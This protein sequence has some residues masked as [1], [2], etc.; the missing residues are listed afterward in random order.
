MGDLNNTTA[1]RPI[2][3]IRAGPAYHRRSVAIAESDD[4]PEIRTKYRPFL[5]DSKTVNEDWVSE[6]EL[7][8][9][10]KMAEQDLEATGKRLKVLMLFGS[11]RRRSAFPAI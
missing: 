1:A 8:T 11:L 6:L 9:V 5:L 4:D 2:V 10:T 3:E 7:S